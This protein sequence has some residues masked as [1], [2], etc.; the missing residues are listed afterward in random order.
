MFGFLKRSD[1]STVSSSL[2][3]P[4][5]IPAFSAMSTDVNEFLADLVVELVPLPTSVSSALSIDNG[6]FSADQVGV[7]LRI[8]MSGPANL[9][10]PWMKD[11]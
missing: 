3:S 10:K 11:Q 4:L 5:A 7:V 6:K 9:L 1:L 2:P 8:E